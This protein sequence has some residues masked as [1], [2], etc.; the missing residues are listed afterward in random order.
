MT[1]L[2]KLGLEA[3]KVGQFIV[4]SYMGAVHKDVAVPAGDTLLAIVEQVVRAEISGTSLGLTGDQKRQLAAA[5]VE[6]I[7][8]KSA[9]AYKKELADPAKFQAD[10]EKLVGVVADILNDF[11][12][13][14][15]E[16]VSLN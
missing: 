6:Q 1:F 2:K 12:D 4:G 11:S 13:S 15:V 5:V 14:A 8:L 10:V 3:L 9:L 7:I 16:T